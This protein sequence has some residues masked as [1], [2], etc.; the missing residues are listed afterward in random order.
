MH[1]ETGSAVSDGWSVRENEVPSRLCQGS[2]SLIECKPSFVN[3]VYPPTG[4][5]KPLRTMT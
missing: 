5:T 4:H 3:V 2:G 1:K